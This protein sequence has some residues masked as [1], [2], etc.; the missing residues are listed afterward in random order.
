[1]AA[2]IGLRG[3]CGRTAETALEVRLDI[4]GAVTDQGA[5]LHVWAALPKKPVAADAGHAPLRDAGIL[6]F[7]EKG[8]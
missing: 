7:G 4:F 8:F 1:L 6:A 2:T 3:T 5:Q